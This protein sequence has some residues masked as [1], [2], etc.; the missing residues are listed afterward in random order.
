MFG[1][2]SRNSVGKTG[3]SS[4][5]FVRAAAGRAA[6]RLV[7]TVDENATGEI[8]TLRLLIGAPPRAGLEQRLRREMS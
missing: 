7:V 4:S 2:A 3:P 6:A 1:A 8:A 5:N